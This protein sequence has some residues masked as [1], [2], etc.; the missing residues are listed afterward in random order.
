VR[1]AAFDLRFIQK[2]R[3]NAKTENYDH[4]LKEDS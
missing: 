2:G 1:I 3:K 4:D